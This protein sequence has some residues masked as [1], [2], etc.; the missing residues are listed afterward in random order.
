MFCICSLT[1]V[2]ISLFRLRVSGSVDA[3]LNQLH[4]EFDIPGI[5]KHKKSVFGTETL[6][7]IDRLLCVMTPRK[8][9]QQTEPRKVR[10]SDIY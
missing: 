4:H 1:R 6:G 10:V 8:K 9:A 3:E 7:N 2:L 5:S